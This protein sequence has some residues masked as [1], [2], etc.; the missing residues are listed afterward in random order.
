MSDRRY[1][2]S[3]VRDA[4]KLLGAGATTQEI[5]DRADQIAASKEEERGLLLDQPLFVHV[6]GRIRLGRVYRSVS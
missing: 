5:C 3:A 6:V 2:C 4:I 1:G